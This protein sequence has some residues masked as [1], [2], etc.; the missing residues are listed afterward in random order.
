MSVMEDGVMNLTNISD[1]LA[2]G[3]RDTLARA[4]GKNARS[5]M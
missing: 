4:A 5:T 2:G 1:V 3:N